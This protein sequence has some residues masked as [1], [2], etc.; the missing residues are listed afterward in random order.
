MSNNSGN[1]INAGIIH[2]SAIT[3][4]I[5]SSPQS[6]PAEA[7]LKMSVFISYRRSA[8]NILAQSLAA[9]LEK[10]IEGEVFLDRT[11]LGAGAFPESL[12]EALKRCQIVVLLVGPGTLDTPRLFQENDWVRRELRTALISQKPIL[13]VA[14]DQTEFAHK[15]MLPDDLEGLKKMHGV[16]LYTDQLHRSMMNVV[17]ALANTL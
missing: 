9:E 11:G 6:T 16:R 2:Q 7:K 14:E 1:Q 12:D 15:Y 3:Q 17:D 5:G 10:H 4:Q 8:S 13:Q